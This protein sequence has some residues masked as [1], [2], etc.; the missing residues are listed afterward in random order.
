MKGGTDN[1]IKVFAVTR[2]VSTRTLAATALLAM[3]AASSNAAE[4]I[5]IG[6][7]AWP[8][9]TVTAH[10]V[11]NV[12]G[13][14]GYEAELVELGTM[15]MLAAVARGDVDVHP[16]VWFPN[17]A[18]ALDKVNGDG[19][20]TIGEHGVEARQNI[21]VTRATQE[22]T[23]IKALADLADPGMAAR[24]DSD[25][26]GKGE[27]WIGAPS[28]SS[29]E[30]E[31]VRA[32]SY[33]YFL[34]M[35]LLQIPEDIAMAAVD[36]AAS[37]GDPVVFYCYAPHHVFDLHDL[38]TLEEPPFDP[39]RWRLVKRADDPGWLQKSYAETA[40][41]AS[42]FHVGYATALR[43]R[44]PALERFLAGMALEP[45]DVNALS[46]AFE[47]EGKPAAEVAAAWIADNEDRVK[48]WMK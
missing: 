28:W 9:A 11:A 1:V 48:E 36:V 37:L 31:L 44:A 25:N 13:Q 43:E 41:D 30:I 27:I 46:Y 38:V 5:R 17:L 10:I 6:V 2:A 4:R 15:T 3:A 14:M 8:S 7:P 26:N 42:H 40:W 23:G 34:T 18:D 19:R 32:R 29:T 12:A 47:V 20:V 21:C 33:G 45:A 16:E 22:Q 39:A 24:F 35:D